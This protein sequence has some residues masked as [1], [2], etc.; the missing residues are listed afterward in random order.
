ARTIAD[1]LSLLFLR[2]GNLVIFPFITSSAQLER[3]HLHKQIAPI[4]AKLVFAGAVGFSLFATTAELIVTIIF[5]ERY[6]EAAWML[7]ILFVGAWFSTM[8]SINESALLGLGKPMYSTIANTVKFGWL[9]FGLPM[10]F[11]EYGTIGAIVAVAVSDIIRYV[12]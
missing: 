6:H 1:L 5:D 9:L 7:P 3:A 2:L 8:C 4:R 11:A 10:G 12:P